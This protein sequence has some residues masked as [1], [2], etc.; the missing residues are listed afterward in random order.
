METECFDV[1]HNINHSR[2]LTGKNNFLGCYIDKTPPQPS[3][4]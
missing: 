4:W 2:N 3:S 1:S